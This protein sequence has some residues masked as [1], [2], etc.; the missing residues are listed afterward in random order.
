MNGLMHNVVTR[1]ITEVNRLLYA[2]A[3]VVAERLGMIKE[4]KGNQRKVEK[5]QEVAERS[6]VSGCCQEKEWYAVRAR[7]LEG[8]DSCRSL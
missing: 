3:F 4:R 2:G 7:I 5:H 1:N 8:Q 6:W